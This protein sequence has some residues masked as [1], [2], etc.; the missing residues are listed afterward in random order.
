M[1]GVVSDKKKFSCNQL[2]DNE[3]KKDGW[4]PFFECRDL[5]IEEATDRTF[6]CARYPSGTQRAFGNAIMI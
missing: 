3:F 2:D 4:R 6:F 5:G 1:G